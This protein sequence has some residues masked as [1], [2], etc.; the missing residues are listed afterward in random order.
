MLADLRIIVAYP[1]KNTKDRVRPE[2]EAPL[3]KFRPL[4]LGSVVAL[5]FP[6]IL[7]ALLSTLSSNVS[8]I[9]VMFFNYDLVLYRCRLL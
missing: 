2:T 8:D 1:G 4:L 3:S 9:P 5:T 6:Y 7:S